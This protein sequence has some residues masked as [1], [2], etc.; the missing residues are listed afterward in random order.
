MINPF[1][2]VKTPFKRTEKPRLSNKQFKKIVKLDLEESPTLE[3]YRDI[4]L[5]LCYTGFSY[6]DTL[7]IRYNDIT[8]GF[9]K[10]HRKSLKYV[11]IGLDT[12]YTIVRKANTYNEVIRLE[13]QS[14]IP[15]QCP[16]NEIIPIS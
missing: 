13:T 16:Q 15:I 14:R 9:L 8:S 10:I 2:G 4:F 6:C 1:L 11:Q 3:V 12:E 7:D 5:F